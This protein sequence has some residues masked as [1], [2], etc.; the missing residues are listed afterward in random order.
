MYYRYNFLLLFKYI[1]YY[2]NSLIYHI[3]VNWNYESFTLNYMRVNFRI[4]CNKDSKLWLQTKPRRKVCT[5]ENR[6][7]IIRLHR[8]DFRFV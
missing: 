4:K 2:L 3:L 6:E 7:I 1:T 5:T 8:R